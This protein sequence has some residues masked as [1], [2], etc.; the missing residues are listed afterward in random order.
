[1]SISAS[2]DTSSF[3]VTDKITVFLNSVSELESVVPEWAKLLLESIKVMITDF[4]DTHAELRSIIH[5]NNEQIT[6]LDDSFKARGAVLN[7]LVTDRDRLVHEV[8]SLK[9]KMENIENY[10]RRSCLLVHGVKEDGGENTDD[11]ALD[12]INNNLNLK[13]ITI[14]DIARSH[15]IGRPDKS[16]ETRNVKPRVRPIIVKFVS[17]RDRISVYRSKKLLKGKRISISENL[18]IERYIL[19]KKCCQKFGMRNCWTFDSMIFA[20][21][22]GVRKVITCDED[23]ACYD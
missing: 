19:F 1:M 12:I 6:K 21:I 15:R 18:S 5:E 4:K 16:R 10:S 22:N 7:A 17:D 8:S 2:S 14:K 3:D 13:N 23:L 20:H 9:L 11:I